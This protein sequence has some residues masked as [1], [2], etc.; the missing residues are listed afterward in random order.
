MSA[1]TLNEGNVFSTKEII[2]LLNMALSHKWNFSYLS[3]V[4]NHVSSKP[5]KLLS[6]DPQEGT[7]GID[8]EIANSGQNEHGSI[9]FRAQSGG[10]SLVFNA[11]PAEST[12]NPES[13]KSL[14][15]WQVNIP[16]EIRISQL[17]KSVRVNMESGKTIPVILYSSEGMRVQGTVVDISKTGAK[18]KISQDM[19]DKLDNFEVVDALRI[20]LPSNDMVQC[21]AQIMGVVYDHDSDCTQIRCQFTDMKAR[22]A[23]LL[24]R[25]IT[26]TIDRTEQQ[27]SYAI[28]S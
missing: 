20:R 11:L 17:R 24:D 5:I 9:L 16:D 1:L 15:E 4:K 10:L 26:H 2:E 7:F 21:Q 8:S 13:N 6:V 23:G 18:I 25:M 19:A 12:G 27:P 28:A 3:F 22:D 14:F